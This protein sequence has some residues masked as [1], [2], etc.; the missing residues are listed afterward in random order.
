MIDTIRQSRRLILRFVPLLL[1]A[2]PAVSCQRSDPPAPTAGGDK[3]PPAPSSVTTTKPAKKTFVYKIEQPG[4][5]QAY[6]QTPIYSYL[7]GFVKRV[8]K[9]IDDRVKENEVLAVM[10]VPALVEQHAE[11]KARV[12]QAEVDIELAK[13]LEE[14]ARKNVEYMQAK[15]EEAQAARD[16]SEAQLWRAES[17]Y[18]RLKQRK[19]VISAEAIEETQLGAKAAKAALKEIDARIKSAETSKAESEAKHAKAVADIDAAKKRLEVAKAEER[20]LA[21]LL[22]YTELRAP[23]SGVVTQ[24]HVDPGWFLQ[25]SGGGKA[26][27]VF[28]I[29]HTDTV[30]IFV[31]VPE[32]DAVLIK[33]GMK[34]VV[35]V[36]GLQGEEF[37]GEVKRTSFSLDGKERILRTEIDL[38]NP[39]GRLRPNMYAYATIEVQRDKYHLI[40]ATAVVTSGNKTYCL[41][42]DGDNKARRTPVRLGVRDGQMV[43]VVKKKT[44]GK[45]GTWVDFTGDE[46]TVTSHPATLTDGQDVTVEK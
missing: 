15:I 46:K 11:K 37:S 9:D 19:D 13:K 7:S 36:Q 8:D 22:E 45:D 43:E 24:R 35:S 20:S 39:D 29:A 3:Q 6:Y 18:E 26:E 34:A 32:N 31:D 23:Y 27:P 25:P 2:L 33:D 42:V 40:P 5:I 17:Q 30:R 41:I 28:V 16:G 44:P 1:L 38:K 4:E 10:S 21:A 12:A 14:A